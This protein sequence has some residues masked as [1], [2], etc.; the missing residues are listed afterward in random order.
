M[1]LAGCGRVERW[2]VVGALIKFSV[3]AAA[4]RADARPWFVAGVVLAASGA[5]GYAFVTRQLAPRA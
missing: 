4:S 5:A 1:H 3:V 2:A